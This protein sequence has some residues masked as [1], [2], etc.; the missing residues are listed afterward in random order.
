MRMRKMKSPSTC[1]EGPSVRDSD[2]FPCSTHAPHFPPALERGPDAALEPEAIDRRRRMNRADAAK[3]DAGPLESA[4]LQHAPRRRIGDA[5]RRLQRLV[6]DI[7]ERMVDQRA[8][9]LGGVAFALMGLA[10]PAADLRHRPV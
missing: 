8:H 7:A 6:A 10:E 4:F 9:R 1:A 3:A 5:R 2:S